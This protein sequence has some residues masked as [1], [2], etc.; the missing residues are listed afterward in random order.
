[1]ETKQCSIKTGCGEFKETSEFTKGR[2]TCKTCRGIERQLYLKKINPLHK[3]IGERKLERE[4]NPKQRK[5]HPYT[6]EKRRELGLKYRYGITEEDYKK[7]LAYQK[8]SCGI[9]GITEED[10]IKRTSHNKKPTSLFIDHCHDTGSVRG[11]LCDSCNRGLGLL[12][13]ST[14]NIEK[15]LAYLTK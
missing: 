12:G 8:N 11:I 15:A 9:C 14:S 3:S 10:F 2:T 7:I 4:A 6:K 5:Q 13:D 1:M